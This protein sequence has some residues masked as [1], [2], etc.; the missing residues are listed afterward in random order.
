[1][2]HLQEYCFLGNH[3]KFLVF[4]LCGKTMKIF[5]RNHTSSKPGSTPSL[6]G[7]KKRWFH[8]SRK[9]FAYMLA[10]AVLCAGLVVLQRFCMNHKEGDFI[11]SYCLTDTNMRTVI[12]AMLTLMG[13]ALT[14][15]VTSTVEAY[16]TTRLVYGIN[17]GVYIAMASQNLQYLRR[18]MQTSW[19]PVIFIIILATTA[20][21]LLQTLVNI[22]IKTTGVYVRNR[23]NVGIY[24]GYAL[25]NTTVGDLNFANMNIAILLLTKMRDLKTS[26]TVGPHPY[27]PHAEFDGLQNTAVTSVIRDGYFVGLDNTDY[28]T[29]NSVKHLETVVTITTSCTSDDLD[30]NLSSEVPIYDPTF[31]TLTAVDAAEN[32]AMAVLS[33]YKYEHM[34]DGS[35]VFTSTMYTAECGP[36]PTYTLNGALVNCSA[37]GPDTM[38]GGQTSS[39]TSAIVVQDQIIIVTVDANTITPVQLVSNTTTV[40]TSDLAR[41]M[42]NYAESPENT[43]KT[44]DN[45][46][47]IA[48]LLYFYAN[49][50]QGLFG[51]EDLFP[52]RN[53][54]HTK[55]C[56]AASLA[57]GIL[58]TTKERS[59][60]E[61]ALGING[62]ALSGTTSGTANSPFSTVQLHNLVQVTYIS[63]ANVAIIVCV[64]TSCACFVSLLGTL[65]CHQVGDQHQACD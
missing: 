2:D 58:F 53:V 39:C 63:T 32:Y 45:P 8:V 12:A 41:L 19:A 61:V 38:I 49:F 48:R 29:S 54:L 50:P 3:R 33:S 25:Y 15:A 52:M 14:A 31:V 36:V 44:Q 24:E 5:K 35:I 10:V 42:V 23:S 30:G 27:D 55:L 64:V 6:M 4:W 46:S 60:E 56:A 11:T 16:R 65:F 43:S 18:A 22:G 59:A 9:Y 17:E 21:Q 20:P 47:Y 7:C 62:F 26:A 34:P 28:Y 37:F 1:M 40:N 51:N 57:L 13:L